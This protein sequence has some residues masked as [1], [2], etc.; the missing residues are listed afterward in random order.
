MTLLKISCLTLSLLIT[1][2]LWS[3]DSMTLV[4][5]AAVNL[6]SEGTKMPISINF[7]DSRASDGASRRQVLSMVYREKLFQGANELDQDVEKVAVKL[8]DKGNAQEILFDGTYHLINKESSNGWELVLDG[9]ITDDPSPNKA[10]AT[11]YQNFH[12][13]L[14]CLDISI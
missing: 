6:D 3:K 11:F 9:I 12:T 7:R 4:C 2:N 13:E 5:S 1:A 8:A 10:K 14:P